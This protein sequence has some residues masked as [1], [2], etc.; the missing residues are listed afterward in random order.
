MRTQE[1]AAFDADPDSYAVVDV[2]AAQKRLEETFWPKLFR[3]IGRVPFAESA[4]AAWYCAIDPETPNRAKALLFGSLIYFVAPFDATPDFI[5]GL[6]LLDDATVIATVL[7]IVG[8]HLKPRHRRQARARLGKPER[9]R[10]E[11]AD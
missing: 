9:M 11:A 7:S 1:R 8:T 2:D 5:V 6:G 10:T 3:M 4:A